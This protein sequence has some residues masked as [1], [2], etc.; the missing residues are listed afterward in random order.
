MLAFSLIAS[1]RCLARTAKNVWVGAQNSA[2]NNFLPLRLETYLAWTFLF[3][4][5]FR[6]NWRRDKTSRGPWNRTKF[7]VRP[8]QAGRFESAHVAMCFGSLGLQ[9]AA[10]TSARFV[11]SSVMSSFSRSSSSTALISSSPVCSPAPNS[12]LLRNH[13]SLP[14]TVSEKVYFVRRKQRVKGRGTEQ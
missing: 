7:S 13:R 5:S 9:V 10:S 4:C 12:R 8:S 11:S 2:K 6:N 1:R 3:L 14:R